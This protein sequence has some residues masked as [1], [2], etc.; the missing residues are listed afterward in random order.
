[1]QGCFTSSRSY[2]H[3]RTVSQAHPRFDKERGT[4]EGRRMIK[5]RADAREAAGLPRSPGRYPSSDPRSSAA[6]RKA[7]AA[8]PE[9]RIMS[10]S[11]APVGSGASAPDP[12]VSRPVGTGASA[13][14][15][16]MSPRAASSSDPLG[17]AVAGTGARA[18]VP[19]VAGSG[20]SSDKMPL[21]QNPHAPPLGLSDSEA[22]EFRKEWSRKFD[23]TVL[24]HRCITITDIQ[25]W[26]V[27]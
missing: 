19:P 20:A 27:Q 10:K 9:R 22:L 5:A 14:V 23:S 25:T 16:P 6:K 18:P 1:M 24:R 7:A 3:P 21:E 11:P 13:P 15:P 2:T 8:R 26:T 17:S 12:A 4:K